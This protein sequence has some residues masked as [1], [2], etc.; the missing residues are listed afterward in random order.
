MEK[1]ENIKISKKRGRPK[2]YFNE[3]ERIHAQ[4]MNREKYILKNGLRCE[5]CN[6]V[7][8]T[9]ARKLNHIRTMKHKMNF[10]RKQI[11]EAMEENMSDL[12][13]EEFEDFLKD[14][15]LTGM[16]M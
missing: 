2:K 6:I 15:D 11:K 1:S 13:E 8:S 4:K 12:S 3:E 9:K 5:C 14:C 16:Y 7:N 10:V